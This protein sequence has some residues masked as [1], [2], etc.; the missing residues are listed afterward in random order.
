MKAKARIFSITT[1]LFLLVAATS[2]VPAI[3]SRG[4][5]VTKDRTF[6]VGITFR[7]NGIDQVCSGALISSSIILTAAHCVVGA[8]GGT[9]TDF[10]F[11]P[12]GTAIDAA[13]DPRVTPPKIL[14]I[15]KSDSYMSSATSAMD[16]IAFIE[17]DKALASKGFIRIATQDELL[18]LN[19]GKSL[20][21]YGF[22]YVYETNSPYSSFPR[23]YPLTWQP[24]FSG[25]ELNRTLDLT[26][27][28]ASGCKG[29]SGGPITTTL[30]SGEEVL[31]GVLSGAASV[32]NSCGTIGSDGQFHMLV[33][34][35]NPYLKELASNL[36][37]RIN[38]KPSPT[39]SSKKKI[40]KI[41]CVKGK[42]KKV[43]SG[44]NPKCPKGYTKK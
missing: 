33:T 21:G 42:V 12:P 1:C 39:P 37:P 11:S 2:Y 13:I 14:K 17:L 38:T 43:V 24:T 9:N 32:Q 5:T 34:M 10:T 27:S 35:I 3:A 40:I 26:S 23:K 19:P 36:L 8:N 22:G 7:D 16:D 20:S 6:V 44:T 28:S 25:L 41:T 4:G 29:D 18:K 15:Y 31:V 30:A